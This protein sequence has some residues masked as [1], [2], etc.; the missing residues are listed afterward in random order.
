MTQEKER[1]NKDMPDLDERKNTN[2]QDPENLNGQDDLQENTEERKASE[3]AQ[4]EECP[5]MQDTAEAGSRAEETAA[6]DGAEAEENADDPS[7]EN[8]EE[9][10]VE[11]NFRKAD[12][13]KGFFR[14]KKDP[15]EER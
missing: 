8:P 14:R 4:T 9:D 15:Q 10:I 5:E 2:E 1:V 3:D 13:K 11:G 12:E 7:G 6:E